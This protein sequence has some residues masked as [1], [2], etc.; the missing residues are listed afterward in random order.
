MTPGT[1]HC[2]EATH[3]LR[4][5]TPL[6]IVAAVSHAGALCPTLLAVLAMLAVLLLPRHGRLGGGGSM[7]MEAVLR[8]S[9]SRPAHVAFPDALSPAKPHNLPKPRVLSRDRCAAHVGLSRVA[10]R[11]NGRLKGERWL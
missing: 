4:I 3:L 8:T 11:P 9:A 5:A 2:Q 6:L 1:T 7:M 10:G